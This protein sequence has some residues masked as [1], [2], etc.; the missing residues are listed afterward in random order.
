MQTPSLYVAASPPLDV[1]VDCCQSLLR[2]RPL[3]LAFGGRAGAGKNT[4]AE[5]IAGNNYPVINHAD[6]MKEEVLEWLTDAMLHGFDP[7]GD[8]AF[9]HFA[10]FMGISPGRI[11]DDLWDLIGPVYAS[12]VKLFLTA[13][14]NRYKLAPYVGLAPGVQIED[15]VAFVE[16]NKRDF[17]QPLQLYGQ[18]SK[19]IT[20]DPDYWVHRT[21]S[22]SIGQAICFN[23][24]TRFPSEAACLQN[25]AWTVVYL[26]IDDETQ[27]KR[28]PEMTEQERMHL[29]EWAL[30][31]EHCDLTVDANGPVSS[32]L[33]Q[34]ADYLSANVRKKVMA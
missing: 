25:C 19:E 21:I 22:R 28:R 33:M 32:V 3:R 11:Q 13:K 20:A 10:N 30:R 15:K 6:T 12:F 4:A 7:E 5:L 8:E 26:Q 2:E 27:R 9:E 16:M 29:S 31:P 17:R 1:A 18:M 14:R 23:A 34:I 24:D